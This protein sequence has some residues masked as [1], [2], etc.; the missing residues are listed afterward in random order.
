MKKWTGRKIACLCWLLAGTLFL[1]AFLACLPVMVVYA[2]PDETQQQGE[3]TGQTG[4][5]TQQGGDETQQ[6][7][8]G[9]QQGGEGTQQGGEGTQQGGEG[10][11]Q[12]EEG[13]QQGEEGTQQGGEG[14]QQGD[15]E[16]QQ[17]G[18]GT[19]QGGEGTQQGG[20][21]TQTPEDIAK[22]PE[23]YHSAL[24]AL[25]QQHP[26]WSFEPLATGLDWSTA[27]TK[28]MQDGKSLIHKSLANC[29]KEGAYDQGNWFYASRAALE[30]YMDPR[31]A[32]TEERIFQFEQL[33]YHAAYHTEEALAKILEGTFMNSGVNVPG[34]ELKYSYLIHQIGLNEEVLVSPFHLAARIVQEQG[35]GTGPM[36]SGTYPGFEGYYN[37]FNIGAT[38]RTNQEV[39]ENGLKYA[40]DYWGKEG[41]LGAYWALLGGAK[42]IAS[43]YIKKGQDTLY[44]QKFN[45]NP[46]A[47]SALYT[48]Q[49]MQNVTAPTTEAKSIRD[50]YV[51]ANALESPFVFR[52]PVYENMPDTSCPKPTSS[53]NIVLDLPEDVKVTKVVVDEVEYEGESFYD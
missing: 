46:N 48:H 52:I 6:G 10:T 32:L 39:I 34:T 1:Q 14:T 50:L 31:N 51:S 8:E 19:Q 24:L 7:G 43:G 18:E 37:Y 28:E 44:L 20:E 21:G 38:G 33:T 15:D 3:T 12:G 5:T 23:S 13:T 11:Q 47:K 4:D 27:V 17:G 29:M 40:R 2:E 35:Q 53:T 42:D 22:F 9:T 36:I 45:V 26:A 30:H 41:G 49:Y 16:T 25:K